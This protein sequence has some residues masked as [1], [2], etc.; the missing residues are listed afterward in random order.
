MKLENNDEFE[1]ETI[2][3]QETK[4]SNSRNRSNF[5]HCRF[6]HGEILSNESKK[7]FRI[8]RIRYSC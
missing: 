4:S 2:P 5:R 1:R 6:E 3:N 7:S 8:V